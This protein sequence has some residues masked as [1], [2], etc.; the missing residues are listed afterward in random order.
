MIFLSF[1]VLHFFVSL[2]G[3]SAT[4]RG[5]WGEVRWSLT[6]LK[7][8]FVDPSLAIFLKIILGLRWL[9][10]V[11]EEATSQLISWLN[12]VGPDRLLYGFSKIMPLGAMRNWCNGTESTQTRHCDGPCGDS[13]SSFRRTQTSLS[14]WTVGHAHAGFL[15]SRKLNEEKHCAIIGGFAPISG[16][17]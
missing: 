12:E 5:D 8:N 6:Y 15:L 10:C 16:F 11:H 1:I 4:G 7:F 17:F 9:D 14:L 2:S 13:P 3:G